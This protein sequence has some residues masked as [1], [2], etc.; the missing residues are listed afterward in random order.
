MIT[1]MVV[2]TMVMVVVTMV[3]VVVPWPVSAH[4]NLFFTLTR[5]L[6]MPNK[7]VSTSGVNKRQLKGAIE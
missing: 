1:V 5:I 4:I 2:V 7:F 6:P 3:M